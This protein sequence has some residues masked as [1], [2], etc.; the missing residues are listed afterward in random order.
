ML[1][2]PAF[3]ENFGDN[4]KHDQNHQPVFSASSAAH[5]SRQR[6]LSYLVLPGVTAG[7]KLQFPTCVVFFVILFCLSF[8]QEWCF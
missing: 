6:W 5:V 8:S 1:G 7:F 2:R 3:N 4:Y